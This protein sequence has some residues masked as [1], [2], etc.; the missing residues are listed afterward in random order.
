MS[1]ADLTHSILQGY[2]WP[3]S[4]SFYFVLVMYFYTLKLRC[5][6]K[7]D[8][9]RKITLRYAALLVLYARQDVDF[10]IAIMLRS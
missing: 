1:C 5:L 8:K 10:Y 4:L 2:F 9:L 6:R 7:F 3:P